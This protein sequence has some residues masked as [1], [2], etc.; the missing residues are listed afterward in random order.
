MQ[1]DRLSELSGYLLQ[2]S[3]REERIITGGMTVLHR[4]KQGVP[5]YVQ[6]TRAD[7]L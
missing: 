3:P 6:G 5:V 1:S 2:V 4:L 7:L